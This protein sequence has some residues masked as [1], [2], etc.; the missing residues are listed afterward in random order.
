MANWEAAAAWDDIQAF[1]NE[2][3]RERRTPSASVAVA[4]EGKMVHHH[5]YGLRDTE[6]KLPVT[7]DTVYGIGSIT[8]SF[9]AVAI[10]QL[11]EQGKLSVHDPVVQW[12][13][14]YRTPDAEMTKA[15]T[16]HHL[17]THTAGL[18]PLPSLRVTMRNSMLADPD[19]D[20]PDLRARLQSA[21][22]VETAEQLLG[23]SVV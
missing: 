20:D 13:S 21:T 12:L 17:L 15:T 11:Q 16:L 4:R 5:P 19:V 1:M 14:E 3:L 2:S 6:E 18:P 23:K 9:T 7:P 8:K 10:M 22:S